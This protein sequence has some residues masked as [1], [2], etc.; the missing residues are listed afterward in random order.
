A[1]YILAGLERFSVFQPILRF[2]DTFIPRARLGIG[3]LFAFG[4]ASNFMY[5]YA[6]GQK[7]DV[8][9]I[10][11]MTVVSLYWTLISITEF[12]ISFLMV[13]TFRRIHRSLDRDSKL[14]SPPSSPVSPT[15]KTLSLSSTT[16]S[17]T[18]P[19]LDPQT[20][21]TRLV[22]LLTAMIIT[23]VLAVFAWCS[24]AFVPSLGK[25]HDEAAQFSESWAGVHC[26]LGFYFLS[27]FRSSMLV[28]GDG[29]TEMETK[30]LESLHVGMETGTGTAGKTDLGSVAWRGMGSLNGSGIVR[31]GREWNAHRV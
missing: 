10:V 24:T 13:I 2:S 23:D 14:S 30:S 31:G 7:K 29:V 11:A 27:R 1:L 28:R 21:S 19:R 6:L 8:M 16:H 26:I 17:S 20:E 18:H 25:Y 9:R 12:S 4:I 3:C 5:F 22:R 15:T